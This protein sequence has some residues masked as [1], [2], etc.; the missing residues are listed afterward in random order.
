MCVSDG[1]W[2]PH[3]AREAGLMEAS[4]RAFTDAQTRMDT[5]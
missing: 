2:Q 3:D 5:A 4:K 1:H